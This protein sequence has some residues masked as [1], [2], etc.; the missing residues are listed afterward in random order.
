MAVPPPNG[1]AS[2]PVMAVSLFLNAR[3]ALAAC[4]WLLLAA[5]LA[6]AEAPATAPP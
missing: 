1:L 6:W 4:V 2:L 5:P 3:Q